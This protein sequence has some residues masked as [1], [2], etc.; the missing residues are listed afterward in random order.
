M[1]LTKQPHHLVVGAGLAGCLLTWRLLRSGRS[2]TLIGPS[3]QPG[4]TEAAVGIINPVTGRWMTK[5][6][7]LDT[8]LPEARRLYEELGNYFGASFHR[9]VGL[10][11]YCLNPDD[12]KRIQRR[13]RNPRYAGYLQAFDPPGAASGPFDDTHGSFLI[14]GAIA[15]DLCAVL[16]H[17]RHEF[18][19]QGVF[20]DERFD[21]SVLESRRG[22]WQY[23]DI[24]S[25]RVIFCEGASALQ[26]PWF[27]ELPLTPAKG[28]TIIVASEDLDLTPD[29]HH[30]HKWILALGNRTYRIGSTYDE[31]D[32]DPSPSSGAVD[33]LLDGVRAGC[34]GNPRFR[35]LSHQAGLRPCTPDAR[36]L[37]GEHSDEPGLYVFNGL[38]SKGVSQAPYFSKQLLA[39][40]DHKA[41][42]D[43]EAD[44][45]RFRKAATSEFKNH[46]PD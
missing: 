43:P 24:A 23:K 36:P 30:H 38:G 34:V 14:H 11:R 8:L 17:L 41:P 25:G 2:V 26:N 5:S 22:N 15:V 10:R 20:R 27:P 35:L 19:R 45:H 4:A 16:N 18:A 28:E 6:W 44:L 46:A 13:M 40:L 21:Y 12:A 42:I 1:S 33:E 32:L 29:L 31:N 3:A 9:S 39:H 7:R 37:L